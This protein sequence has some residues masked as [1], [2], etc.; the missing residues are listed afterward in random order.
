MV[1]GYFGILIVSKELCY[2]WTAWYFDSIT[3][4]GVVF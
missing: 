1:M 4:Q 2:N 3:E